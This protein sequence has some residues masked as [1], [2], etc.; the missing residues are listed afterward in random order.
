MILWTPQPLELVF[1][2]YQNDEVTNVAPLEMD[3]KGRKVLVE[4]VDLDKKR[5]VQLISTDPQDYLL[6]DFQPGTI[7]N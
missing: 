7:I 5:I 6:E 2:N 4:T 3:Y 1:D